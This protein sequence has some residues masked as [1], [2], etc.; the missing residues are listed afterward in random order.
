MISHSMPQSICFMNGLSIK[1]QER[2]VLKADFTPTNRVA[3]TTTEDGHSA[4]HL[5]Q[6]WSSWSHCLRL[7]YTKA[8]FCSSSTEPLQPVTSGSNKGRRYKNWPC[9]L[10]NH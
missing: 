8:D 5:L 2:L 7:Y 1:L 10:L 6:L 3:P 9:E 4:P